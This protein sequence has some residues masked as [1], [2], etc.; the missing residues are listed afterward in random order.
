MATVDWKAEYLQ[1]VSEG[2]GH[3]LL[4]RLVPNRISEHEL[5]ESVIGQVTLYTWITHAFWDMSAGGECH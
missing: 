3:P 1:P 2:F 4:E 5:I